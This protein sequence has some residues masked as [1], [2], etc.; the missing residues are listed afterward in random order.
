MT[1]TIVA[2]TLSKR[3]GRLDCGHQAEAGEL[4]FKVDTGERGGSTRSGQG[5]GAWVCEAC[6]EDRLEAS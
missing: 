5:L 3:G 6:S 2:T 1:T 4:I